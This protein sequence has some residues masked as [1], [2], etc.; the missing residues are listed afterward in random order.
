MR[1]F[2]GN[3]VFMIGPEANQYTQLRESDAHVG[4]LLH[5]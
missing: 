1:V 4:G 2:H 5:P 3:S